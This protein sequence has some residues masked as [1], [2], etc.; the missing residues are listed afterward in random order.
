[1]LL[2]EI[3]QANSDYRDVLLPAEYPDYPWDAAK[4]PKAAQERIIQADWKQYDDWLKR[5]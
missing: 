1:M 4:L 5:S 2:R 3:E